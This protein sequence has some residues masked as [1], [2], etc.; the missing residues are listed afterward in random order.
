M[1]VNMECRFAKMK[2]KNLYPNQFSFHT[3][4]T[5]VWLCTKD[6]AKIIDE[7]HDCSGCE[8]WKTSPQKM[9][10]NGEGY[11]VFNKALGEFVRGGN[12][13]GFGGSPMTTPQIEKAKIYG[14][15]NKAKADGVGKAIRFFDNEESDYQI[16]K[17]KI[18][19]IE[20]V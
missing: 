17:V 13:G 6:V 15:A 10:R 14:T 19:V 2:Q 1:Y 20:E 12:A 9:Q 11:V 5:N 18:S 4:R 7:T 16:V 8:I 3:K